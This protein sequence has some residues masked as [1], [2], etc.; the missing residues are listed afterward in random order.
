MEEE[1]RQ[2]NVAGQR[3]LC[4]IVYTVYQDRIVCIVLNIP[5]HIPAAA[6]WPPTDHEAGK[7]GVV[8][9]NFLALGPKYTLTD[10]QALLSRAY[11]LRS[12]RYHQSAF[13][14][15]IPPPTTPLIP[16]HSLVPGASLAR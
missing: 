15:T 14:L 4:I 9:L 12:T 16:S 2:E 7:E 10:T 6:Q 8:K 5:A 3:R 11:R 13:A 1:S